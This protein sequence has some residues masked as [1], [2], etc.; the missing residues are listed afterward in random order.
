MRIKM[1]GDPEMNGEARAAPLGAKLFLAMYGLGKN[2][3]A[4]DDKN[5]PRHH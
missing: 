2:E 4:Q 3:S 5:L 1:H